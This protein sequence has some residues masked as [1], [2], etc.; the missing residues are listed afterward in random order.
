MKPDQY[1]RIVKGGYCSGCGVCAYK[2]PDT[3]KIEL[4]KYGL[5]RPIL[6]ENGNN[7]A[8]LDSLCPFSGK[9]LN[10]TE[11]ADSLF[12][13]KGLEYNSVI[14]YYS[15]LY[16]GYVKDT[17]YRTRGSSGGITTWILEKLLEEKLID[18]VIH[19]A[20]VERTNNTIP[21]A[22]VGYSLSFSVEEVLSKGKSKYYPVEMSNI[23]ADVK[24]NYPDKKFALVGIPCF[25]KAVRLLQNED[26][27]LKN[28]IPFLIG[29]VCGHL[30]STGFA[31]S[32]AWQSGISPDS[33]TKIDFRYSEGEHNANEYFVRTEGLDINTKE[34]KVRIRQNKTFFGYLWGE[35]FFKYKSCDYCD[36]VF[37]E[38][39]DITFG[40]AWLPQYVSDK[41]GTNVLIVRNSQ[42]RQILDKYKNELVLDILGQDETIAS[43]DAGKRHKRDDLKY[44]LYLKRKKNQ[45]Y[46][47]KRVEADQAGIPS[48]RKGIIRMRESISVA[49]HKYFYKALK[50]NDFSYFVRRM[51]PILRSY[52]LYYSDAGKMSMFY[53]RI[54]FY[55][56][57]VAA[58]IK[59]KIK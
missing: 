53:K 48:N 28:Q 21:K 34:P 41:L 58:E 15:D 27:E 29:L 17:G 20:D 59:S 6:N 4:N 33:L 16:A 3:F 38:T 39:A 35:G 22:I 51:K 30:K 40:D 2:Y 1:E 50:K 5:Y 57:A 8:N 36:D 44:R 43:Q 24:N 25:V 47:I 11:L 52:Y 46:P 12:G 7:I 31:K 32:F 9:S 18:G 42:V 14:G 56:R 13:D 45:W 19:A 55:I 26:K 54:Y 37:A 23:L 49:S 10:E